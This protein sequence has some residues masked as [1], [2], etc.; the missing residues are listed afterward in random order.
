MMTSEEYREGQNSIHKKRSSTTKL[1]MI[2]DKINVVKS[3]KIHDKMRESAKE[4]KSLKE[5]WEVFR[6]LSQ[7]SETRI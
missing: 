4:V 6:K 1:E 5:S 2:K 7:D 3:S